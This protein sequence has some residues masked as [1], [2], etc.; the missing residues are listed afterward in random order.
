MSVCV[1]LSR[2]Q[3]VNGIAFCGTVSET[4]DREKERNKTRKT[5]FPDCFPCACDVVHVRWYYQIWRQNFL[6]LGMKKFVSL[7]NSVV[8]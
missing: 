2:A 1:S 5:D 4:G 3:N 6:L 7:C 8:D